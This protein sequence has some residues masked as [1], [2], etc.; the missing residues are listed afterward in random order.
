MSAAGRWI[1][2]LLFLF[3]RGRFEA[4]LREEM[5]FHR[6]Q[7]EEELLSDGTAGREAH[8]RAA[9]Q[10]GNTTRLRERSHDIVA[11]RWETV[12][13]DVRYAVR[14]MIHSPGFA[15]TAI[16]MLAL[17]IGASVAAAAIA[18]RAA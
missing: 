12:V 8:R 15:I 5:E 6:E 9:V 4:E 18:L 2:R 7:I 16:L 1:N 13:Q 3:R 11:F 14:Q 10:F 17:G